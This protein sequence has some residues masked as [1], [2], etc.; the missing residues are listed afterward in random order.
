MSAAQGRAHRASACLGARLLRKE[1]G[2]EGA[3]LPDAPTAPRSASG[4]PFQH[5]LHGIQVTSPD[6]II[7][8][9]AQ[10]FVA[11]NA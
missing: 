9:L 4:M 11:N 2:S 7:I 6:T 3:H 5:H 10:K 1:R 8:A